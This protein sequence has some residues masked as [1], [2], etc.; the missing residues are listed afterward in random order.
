M[1]FSVPHLLSLTRSL[2]LSLLLSFFSSASFS[3]R[4]RSA[5]LFLSHSF[6]GIS[7]YILLF[8]TLP[9]TQYSI[10]MCALWC[11]SLP[12]KHRQTTQ[13][14][15]TNYTKNL[16]SLSQLA[17]LAR[18]LSHCT[19]TSLQPLSFTPSHTL[20]FYAHPQSQ[21]PFQT[22]PSTARRRGIR[23]ET[24]PQSATESSAC[25]ATKLVPS[26]NNS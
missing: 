18:I 2:G 17:R 3:S 24:C 22:G 25:E 12:L 8:L 5:V 7:C 1:L 14:L 16:L 13:S 4:F 23:S 20:R 10:H 6:L 11:P 21:K 15:Q 19:A 26:W 9:R